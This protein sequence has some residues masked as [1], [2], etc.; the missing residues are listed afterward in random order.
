M[1][2]FTFWSFFLVILL[3]KMALQSSAEVL[4]SSTRGGRRAGPAPLPKQKAAVMCPAEKIL[5]LDKIP[6]LDKLHSGTP[7]GFSVNESICIK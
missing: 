1:P 4:S 5:V 3:F 2:L 6:V 7:C